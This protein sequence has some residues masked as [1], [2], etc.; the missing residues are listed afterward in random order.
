MEIVGFN[1]LLLIAGNETTTNLLSN[2]LNYLADHGELWKTL[3]A[4]PDKIDNAVEE[5]LR[6]DAPVHW[7]S[8]RA[9]E[10]TLIADQL[11]KS[12]ENVFVL[13]GSANRDES[14]YEDADTFRLDRQKTGSP[15]LWSRYSFLLGAPLADWRRVTPWRVFLTE[16][17][18]MPPMQKTNAP[19]LVC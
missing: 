5:I 12:G 4:E 16:N 17:K 11:V 7:V 8:R 15:H 10:D 14:H 3:R 18:V 2:L 19:I 13:M 1:M 6:F 9:T